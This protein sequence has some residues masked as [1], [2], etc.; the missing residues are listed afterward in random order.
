MKIATVCV[1]IEFWISICFLFTRLNI[2]TSPARGT[3]SKFLPFSI[4][5]TI[6][7]CFAAW[8]LR[9]F[10]MKMLIIW[11]NLSDIYLEQKSKIFTYAT[12]IYTSLKSRLL[13][14]LWLIIFIKI[15]NNTFSGFYTYK[16]S[17]VFLIIFNNVLPFLT[18][19]LKWIIKKNN[20]QYMYT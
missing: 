19:L 9:I 20:N 8:N 13:F 2:Y 14:S 16:K 11:V 4:V 5:S 10:A 15:N 1:N 7:H 17:V 3:K 18:I 6:L 12:F